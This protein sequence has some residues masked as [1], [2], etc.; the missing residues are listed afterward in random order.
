MSKY[1]IATKTKAD[2]YL[3]PRPLIDEKKY[4]DNLSA[5][6][7]LMYSILMENM[8]ISIK[9]DWIDTNGDIYI[10]VNHEELKEALSCSL[11]SVQKSINKLKKLNLLSDGKVDGKNFSYLLEPVV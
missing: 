2:S 5:K 7:L 9:N 3:L 4:N 6:D 10:F 11:E 1:N 8:N